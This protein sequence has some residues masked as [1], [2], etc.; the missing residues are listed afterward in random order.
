[1]CSDRQAEWGFVKTKCALCSYSIRDEDVVVAKQGDL[2]HKPCW[3]LVES[4]TL[5]AD[6][7]R[8]Q[9]LSRQ[10]IETA[11]NSL[12]ARS[13]RRVGR[14]PLPAEASVGTTIRIVTVLLRDRTQVYCCPCLA[15]MLALPG[16]QLREGA[17]ALVL[18]AQIRLKVGRCTNCGRRSDVLELT[19]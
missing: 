12:R 15:E 11:K 13:N 3:L 19:V 2:F 18:A 10:H 16:Q 4:R 8:L 7:R 17:Q 1:L 5:I 9:K 14:K 6:S